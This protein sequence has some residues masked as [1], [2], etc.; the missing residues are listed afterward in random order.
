MKQLILLLLAA[1]LP[2]CASATGQ[3]AER[4]IVGCDTMQLFALP[5]ESADSVVLARLGDRLK[6]ID[7]PWS[8]GCWRRYVGVWSLEKGVLW[9]ERVETADGEQLFSGAELFPGSAA[10]TRVRAMWFSGEVRY[11]MGETIYYQHDGFVRNLEREW[12]A[13]LKNGRVTSSRAYRNYGY[14]K[15]L[16]FQENAHLLAAAYDPTGLGEVPGNL[17]FTVKFAADSSGMPVHI[18]KAWLV[19]YENGNRSHRKI[20]NLENPL[21]RE[22]LRAFRASTRWNAWWI[23]GAWKEQYY[24]LPLRKNGVAWTPPKPGPGFRHFGS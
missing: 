17:G 14:E 24:L 6:E 8:T 20:E 13:T 3:A 21:L 10:G 15:G 7:A 23:D 19:V 4:L 16:D 22:A 1:V 9:L 18:D 2:F 11:G 5:L 12:K